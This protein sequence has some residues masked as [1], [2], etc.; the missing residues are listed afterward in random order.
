V[1]QGLRPT[2]ETPDSNIPTRGAQYRDTGGMEE[3]LEVL[4]RSVFGRWVLVG[5][6]TFPEHESRAWLS[7]GGECTVVVDV[8]ERCRI[9]DGDEVLPDYLLGDERQRQEARNPVGNY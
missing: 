2:D 5:D 7:D 4:A 1:S 9:M 3:R 8:D 6:P